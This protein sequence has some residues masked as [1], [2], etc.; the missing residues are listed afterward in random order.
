MSQEATSP[1]RLAS[2]QS[3]APLNLSRK[4]GWQWPGMTLVTSGMELQEAVKIC[5]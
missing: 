5:Y 2:S 3:Y 1:K 4:S